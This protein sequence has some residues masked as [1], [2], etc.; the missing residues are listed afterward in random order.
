[1]RI[2][3]T[4]TVQLESEGRNKGPVYQEGEI[5]DFPEVTAQRW[6]RRRKAKLAPEKP[7]PVE[8]TQA[9]AEPSPPRNAEADPAPAPVGDSALG[10]K[11]TTV[12][13]SARRRRR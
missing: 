10:A 9:A 12:R 6:L 7:A 13:S 1:M 3:F 11:E 8:A 5:H 2:V 4:E